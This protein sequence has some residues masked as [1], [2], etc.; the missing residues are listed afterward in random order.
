MNRS[1][2]LW[3]SIGLFSL[4]VTLTLLGGFIYA[5][6][7]IL[8]PQASPMIEGTISDKTNRSNTKIQL[9]G[10]G[11][12]LTKGTGDETGKGY[13]G[14]VK[15]F[16][17]PVLSKPVNIIGNMAVGGHRS[18]QLQQ[19]LEETGVRYTI[20]QA[21]MIVMTIGGN[22]LFSVGQDEVDVSVIEKR[23]PEALQRLQS[24]LETVNELNPDAE[25]YYVGLYNPF[26][27]LNNGAQ[28]SLIVQKWNS[29]VFALLNLYPQMT[30]VPSYDLFTKNLKEYLSADQFH[31]NQMGY[32]RIAKR[33]VQV[34][35]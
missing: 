20:R 34:I 16:L 21:N 17:E 19:L 25:L 32:E 24:I 11:D 14:Y 4:I 23:M 13:I 33:I 15:E 29:E 18:D 30:F 8:M 1:R 2:T 22:D 12:S 31:P 27:A 3:L 6:K 7:D 9:V 28:S 5:I 10:I 26:A 35:E